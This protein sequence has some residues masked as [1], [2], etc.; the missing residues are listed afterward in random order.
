MI[1][2]YQISILKEESTPSAFSLLFLE[3]FAFGA[4]QHWVFAQSLTPVE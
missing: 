4:A 1:D 2:F 3:E